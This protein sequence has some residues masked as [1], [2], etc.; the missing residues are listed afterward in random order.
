MKRIIIMAL[1]ALFAPLVGAVQFVGSAVAKFRAP[2]FANIAEGTHERA[3]NLLTD[4]AVSTRYLIG[5]FGTDA[6]HVAVA[7]T[8]DIAIGVITDEADAAED[9]VAVAL[10][11]ST[12]ETRKAV[13]SAAIAAGAFITSAAS[14]KVR[15]LPT[16]AG[17]YYILG[18]ALTAAAADGDVIE[19]DSCVAVQRVV[20]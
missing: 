20:A 1:S 16:A 19:F 12:G 11:G 9:S 15:T 2:C 5:K 18:I 6:S 17:T 14:G 3:I 8:A 10:L 13:A 7:G 4:A